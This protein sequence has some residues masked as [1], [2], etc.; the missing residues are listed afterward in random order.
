MREA[1]A[2]E[3]VSMAGLQV[4]EPRGRELGAAGWQSARER[5]GPQSYSC[6]ESNSANNPNQEEP[7]WQRDFCLW[8]SEHRKQ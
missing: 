1:S 4:E 3:R 2:Q 6:R 5:T 8:G 7:S